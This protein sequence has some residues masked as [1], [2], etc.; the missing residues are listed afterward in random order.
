M[1]LPE[2]LKRKQPEPITENE[3]RRPE[4]T[5]ADGNKELAEEHLAKGRVHQAITRYKKAAHMENTPGHRTDLGDAYAFAEL[6]LKALQQYR[7]AL[8]SNP[9][10]PEP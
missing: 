7:R 5:T 3:K 6:P 10:T 2:F 1:P 9:N 4:P 8:K